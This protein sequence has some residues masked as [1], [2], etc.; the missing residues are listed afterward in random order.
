MKRV[1]K[2]HVAP[3]RDAT[4]C[5]TNSLETGTEALATMTGHED[6]LSTRRYDGDPFSKPQLKLGVIVDFGNHEP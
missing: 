2:L 3:L 5:L 6:E 1:D 4:K